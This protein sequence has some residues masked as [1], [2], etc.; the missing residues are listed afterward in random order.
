MDSATLLEEI[1]RVM[2]LV[3][4]PSGD[5][6]MFHQSGCDEC[7]YVRDDLEKYS[8]P[9]LPNEAIRYLYDEMSCLSADGWRWVLPSYLKRCITQDLYDPIETEFLIYNLAPEEKYQ[10]ESRQRL[11]ALSQEQLEC[12][13]HFIEWC[14]DHP[15]WSEYCS[16]EIRA[17]FEFLQ[18]CKMAP[19]A[20]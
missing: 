12:L 19:Y 2:P 1:E 7:R 9:S 17:A 16:K 14:K 13:I 15:H 4:K 5:S 3:P 18:S 6:I 20:N 8:E 11:S 10:A